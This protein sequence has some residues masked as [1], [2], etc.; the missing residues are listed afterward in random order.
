M[1]TYL[2]RDILLSF[3]KAKYC[4]CR[5][6]HIFSGIWKTGSSK[7]DPASRDKDGCIPLAVYPFLFIVFSDGILEDYNIYN[8]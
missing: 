1:Y 3:L 7:N 5:S 6:K 2:D 8:P 4:L